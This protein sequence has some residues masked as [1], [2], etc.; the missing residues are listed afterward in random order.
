MIVNL[1]NA[2]DLSIY[3]SGTTVPKLNQERM[4]SIQI[5]LPPLPEQRRI[6]DIIEKKLTSVEKLKKAAAEQ[7][8]AAGALAKVYLREVFEFD[9]LPEGWE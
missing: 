9:E 5:H 7:Q 4:R 1:L 2:M 6:A 8:E 3:I